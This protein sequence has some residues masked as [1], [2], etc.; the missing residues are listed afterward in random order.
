[1]ARTS[2]SALFMAGFVRLARDHFEA[3]KPDKAIAVL[4]QAV[5]LAAIVPTN[6]PL[7]RRQAYQAYYNLAEYYFEAGRSEAASPY[8]DKANELSETLQRTDPS[9]LL[10]M[11]L[12]SYSRRLSGRVAFA[13]ERWDEALRHFEIMLE[14][15]EDLAEREPGVPHRQFE[16]ADAHSWIGKTAR[17]DSQLDR[18]V[19]HHKAACTIFADLL[20]AEPE[21]AEYAVMLTHAEVHLAS[22]HMSYKTSDANEVA[23]ELF[24]R[25]RQRVGEDLNT[26]L[27]QQNRI[28]DLLAAIDK[29]VG[30]LNRRVAPDSK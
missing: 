6:N 14:V 22:D 11:R 26:T 9:D 1:M 2:Q 21:T 12:G 18:A 19:E 5:D 29:S 28:A 30:T 4:Q 25:A 23:L 17:K 16:I 27:G 15:R 8:C 13:Q 7:I 24:A 20:E 10:F 3:R